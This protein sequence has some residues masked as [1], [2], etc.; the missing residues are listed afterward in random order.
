MNFFSSDL[1]EKFNHLQELI[2]EL[3]SEDLMKN[4]QNIDEM[5]AEWMPIIAG[6]LGIVNE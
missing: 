6:C 3:L 5:M 1:L 2:D 4:L